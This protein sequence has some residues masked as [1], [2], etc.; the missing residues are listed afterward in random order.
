MVSIPVPNWTQRQ[1]GAGLRPARFPA[2]SGSSGSEDPRIQGYGGSLRLLLRFRE[3]PVHGG[4]ER[5]RVEFDLGN[6]G[7]PI[8]RAVRRSLDELVALAHQ[9]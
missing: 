4:P 1:Y 3:H 5:V 2:A 6:R 9:E 8:D 7:G